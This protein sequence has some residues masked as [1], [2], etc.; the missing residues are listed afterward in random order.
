MYMTSYLLCQRFFLTVIMLFLP[1]SRSAGGEGPLSF[2]QGAAVG[3]IHS[4]ESA[5]SSTLDSIQRLIGQGRLNEA[6]RELNEAFKKFPREPALED[7]LGVVN[8]EEGQNEAAERCF[9][10]AIQESPRYTG[11][12]LNLG[13]LYQTMPNHRLQAIQTYRALL[14]FDPANIEANYQC[15]LL[16]LIQGDFHR[17]LG[18]LRKLPPLYARKP[19]ALA[20]ACGDYAAM[21]STSDASSC[22]SYLLASSDLTRP[23]VTPIMP[24]LERFR[25][26]KIAIRLLAG[27][28]DRG[29]ASGN[30][31]EQLGTL[32]VQE[33]ELPEARQAFKQLAERKPDAVTPLLELAHIASRQK[34]YRGA[35][36]YLAHARALDPKNP[37]IHFLFGLVCVQLGLEREAYISLKR[38]VDLDSSN[39]AYVYALGSVATERAD[40]SKS[41]GYFKRY[42]ALKPGDPKGRLA[43]GAAYYFSHELGMARRILLPLKQNPQVAA[44][45]EYYLG[46]IESDELKAAAAVDDLEQSIRRAPRNADAYAVLGGVYLHEDRYAQ[47]EAA[48]GHALRLQ[49]DN[50]LA[51]LDLMIVYQRT[52][53]RRA[54]AQAHR[55]AAVEKQRQQ[56]ARRFFEAIRVVP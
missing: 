38:A 21:G 20:V 28:R 54:P 55:F 18:Q 50:Y 33:G 45:A 44:D 56:R 3:K 4:R 24:A 2:A 11:A 16:E 7:F 49:P 9:Q 48:F 46:R 39:P 17:S 37:R 13:H 34:D 51:N 1:L 32:Y 52:K 27:L 36:G 15:S 23:D 53:D 10:K 5:V 47:A 35:L 31:L 29:M 26:A 41:I 40:P 22:V 43:L 6:R 25:Q 42:C 14:K 8:A 30:D 12:Y 19:Q